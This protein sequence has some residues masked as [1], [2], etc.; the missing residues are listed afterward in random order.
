MVNGEWWTKMKM[1]SVVGEWWSF[2]LSPRGR[3]GQ[4]VQID[5]AQQP[6][7]IILSCSRRGEGR[8]IM[9]ETYPGRPGHG[10]QRGTVHR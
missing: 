10:Q 9:L 7:C 8:E 1:M 2:R 3:G 4:S 6:I 5:P